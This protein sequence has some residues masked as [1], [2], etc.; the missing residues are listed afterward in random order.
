MI[1]PIQKILCPTDFSLPSS[2]AVQAAVELA[3]HFQAKLLL[4]HVVPAIIPPSWATE[5]LERRAMYEPGLFDYEDALRVSALQRLHGLVT[6][7]GG[8]DIEVE[9]LVGK[10]DP[11]SEIVRLAES[12]RADLIVIST[13]G[14]TNYRQLEFGSV[15]ERVVR[16]SY[17][18]VL[19]IRSPRERL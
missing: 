12:K 19:T 5:L 11:A 10:G 2:A 13:H 4:V 15:A 17:P 9:T 6:Q 7:Y 1:L 16:L 8:A 14:M 18:P 3:K